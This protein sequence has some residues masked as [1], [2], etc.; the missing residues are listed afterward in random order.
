MVN[1]E[2]Y[3]FGQM[4]AVEASD[5]CSHRCARWTFNGTPNKDSGGA[6]PGAQPLDRA[7]GTGRE[8]DWEAPLTGSG[9]PRC[10]GPPALPVQNSMR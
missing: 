7:E 5:V 1:K 3:T 10:L 8:E 4:R 6:A 2:I 9:T